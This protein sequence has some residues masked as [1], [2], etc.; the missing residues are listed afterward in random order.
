MHV[1]TIS[2]RDFDNRRDEIIQQLMDAST[3]VGF[4]TLSNHGI[5]QEDVDSMFN[6]SKKFF[7]LPDDV[8][9]KTPLNGKE[10]RLGEEHAGA[11]QHRHGGPEGEH[12]AAVRAHGRAVAQ[13]RGHRRVQAQE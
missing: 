2:L 4:F 6:M 13:R 8:K 3:E 7:A 10:R 12:A 11:P 5:P 9:A 1:P